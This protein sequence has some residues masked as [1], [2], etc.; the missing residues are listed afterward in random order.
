MLECSALGFCCHDARLLERKRVS[1]W[2][3][4]LDVDDIAAR[5]DICIVVL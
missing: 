3:L 5:G 4:D 2:R 1:N